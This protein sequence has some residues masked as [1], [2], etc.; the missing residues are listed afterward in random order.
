MSHGWQGHISLQF[1]LLLAV[2]AITVQCGL[3]LAVSFAAVLCEL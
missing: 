3:G 1:E 2:S